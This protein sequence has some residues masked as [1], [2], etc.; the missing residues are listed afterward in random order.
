MSK[1]WRRLWRGSSGVDVAM[2]MIWA[3][4]RIGYIDKLNG[5]AIMLV[6]MGHV[7]EWGCGRVGRRAWCL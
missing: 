6:V 4:E 1:S 7:A 2:G 3:M 5:M